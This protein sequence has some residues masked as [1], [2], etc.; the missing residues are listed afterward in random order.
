MPRASLHAGDVCDPASL[1]DTVR[2]VQIVFH[3]A[4]ALVATSRR[5]YAAV[6]RD[7]TRNL[8]AA[9][10]AHAPGCRL[11]LVSSLA[12]AGPS[13]DGAGSALPP[14]RCRPVSVYGESKREG[15]LAVVH[16]GLAHAVVRP[17]VVYG[18]G[19]A[20]TR[21]LFRQAAAR[22]TPVPRRP[23]PL[24][25][26]H[27]DDA[28]RALL[29]V[30]GSLHQEGAATG[31]VLPLDGP[32]RTDTHALML[33]L[34]L[35]CGRR[36]RLLPVPLPLAAAAAGACDLVARMTGRPGFFNGDKVRE[37]RA[38]GWVADGTAIRELGFRPAI[39]LLPGLASVALAEGLV[40][41]AAGSAV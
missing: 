5:R 30:A 28:V 34:G 24:S 3:L 17:P 16:S 14:D 32:E 13:R 35:A 40:P 23:R 26:V 36:P 10:R 38:P 7:G 22:V 31:A 37:L 25:I 6:N 21:L 9:L 33:A 1:A 20:A 19:D 12:A 8:T 11:L 15:E 39:A 2:G 41:A 18:P 29:V 27:V 4:G